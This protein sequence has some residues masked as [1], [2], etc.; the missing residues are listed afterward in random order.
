LFFPPS[1]FMLAKNGQPV[2]RIHILIGGRVFSHMSLRGE[3]RRSNLP[4]LRQDICLRSWDCFTTCHAFGSQLRLTA[5]TGLRGIAS[6]PATP[7]ARSFA[8]LAMTRRENVIARRAATKQS[9]GI[10]SRYMSSIMGLLRCLPRLR[11][12]ASAHRNDRFAWDCFTTCH[13]FG[14]QLRLT[15]M[16]CYTC[17]AYLKVRP[18]LQPVCGYPIIGHYG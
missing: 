13:A 5:M 8:S 16:T 18:F 1:I 9:P 17:G 3:Q 15:A 10:A 11:L 12:A 4:V 7:S 14:S 2:K 6:L